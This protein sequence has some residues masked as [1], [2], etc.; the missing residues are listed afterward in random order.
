MV[1][2]TLNDGGSLRWAH[3]LATLWLNA[4]A[5]VG[6]FSLKRGVE[7]PRPMLR[8]PAGAS[9][10][11]GVTADR[12]F[13]W[14]FPR[15]LLR[16]V[17]TTAAADVVFAIGE[18]GLSLPFAY[19]VARLARRPF[20]VYVQSIPHNS[21]QSHLARRERPLW[22]YCLA[23]ADA[24]L[25]VSPNAAASATRLGVEP[26]KITVAPTGIDVDAARQRGLLPA[27]GRKPG[28]V[29]PILVACGELYPHKGYDILIRA[30]AKV[31]ATGR[32]VRLI[33]IG[34]GEE[35]PALKRL[36]RDL[37]VSDRITFLGHVENPLP[38]IAQAAAFV[39]CART[40]AVGLVLLEALALGVPTIAADC[41]AG[42]PRLVLAGGKFG[43]LVAPDSAQ[44]LADAI[45]AHLD[46]PAH[47]ADQASQAEAHL[48]EHFL[49]ERTAALILEVLTRLCGME[50]P[51]PRNV[52]DNGIAATCATGPGTVAVSGSSLVRPQPTNA[53]DGF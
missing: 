13:R 30:L 35:G 25:C 36:A 7:G 32:P 41:E 23:R 24:V 39:H 5:V 20:V 15:T 29:E 22:R 31:H 6:F 44:A 46:N 17:L 1:V 49:P 51:P 42:G 43:H 12:R 10:T 53:S 28:A 33:L 8:P 37:G 21:H 16:A 27:T 19:I 4:G 52:P 40:E 3:Q 2:D 18:V 34:Q 50:Q 38:T 26:S 14:T 11:Y 47:L 9:L 45:C 48:R